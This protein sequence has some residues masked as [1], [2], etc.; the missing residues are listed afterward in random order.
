MIFP[1]KVCFQENRV[2]A[3]IDGGVLRKDGCGVV[4]ILLLV[5]K[6]Y[7]AISDLFKDFTG[8]S[9]PQRCCLFRDSST[10]AS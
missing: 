1:V 4:K 10:V 3:K 9:P 2:N 8:V 6:G 5:S 7:R